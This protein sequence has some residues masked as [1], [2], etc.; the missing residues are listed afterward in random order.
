MNFHVV[1]I[2]SPIKPITLCPNFLVISLMQLSQQFHNKIK[3]HQRPLM[4]GPTPPLS[5]IVQ[6]TLLFPLIKMLLGI[7]VVVTNIWGHN[8]LS[9]GNIIRQPI[10]C[11]C[12]F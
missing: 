12:A 8:V 2:E 1:N 6:L 11:Y 4:E 7:T 10:I 3:C 9:D 5:T